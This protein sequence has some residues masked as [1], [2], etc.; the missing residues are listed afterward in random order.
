MVDP[1]DID[2]AMVI[3][4]PSLESQPYALLI[5]QPNIYKDLNFS[6]NNEVVYSS[7]HKKTHYLFSVCTNKKIKVLSFK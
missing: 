4:M 1:I 5:S 7:Y 6:M 2:R 3:G